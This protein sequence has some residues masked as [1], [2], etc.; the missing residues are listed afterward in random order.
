VLT[1][2]ADDI[3]FMTRRKNPRNLNDMSLGALQIQFIQLGSRENLSLS[4]R[5]K[6]IRIQVW[7]DSLG[8]RKL[9]LPELPNTQYMKV[10]RLS[11]LHTGPAVFT[12]Q[13]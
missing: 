5:I 13:R 1:S 10:I 9:R 6:G 7:T 3:R 4:E 11:S 2:V 8:S 12:G